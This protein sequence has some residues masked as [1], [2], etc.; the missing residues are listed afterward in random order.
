MRG[1]TRQ[2]N[3]LKADLMKHYP[4]IAITSEYRSPEV[5]AGIRARTEAARGADAALWAGSPTGS[6]H[7]WGTALDAVVSPKMWEQ[8]KRDV[9]KRG[10]RAY[11]ENGHIHIDDRTD[12]PDG[13]GE[14][15]RRK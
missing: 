6:S 10:L 5:Q 4:G 11:D 1:N 12:L 2:L 15:K 13:P 7:V 8:F 9:R 14:K 3:A